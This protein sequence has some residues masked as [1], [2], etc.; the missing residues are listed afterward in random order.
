VITVL[1]LDSDLMAV[2]KAVGAPVERAAQEAAAALPHRFRRG[3]DYLEPIHR[4]DQPVS[5]VLLLGRNKEAVAAVADQFR[6]RT[7]R[8]SYLAVCQPPQGAMPELGRMTDL[9]VIDMQKNKTHL[10]TDP[11]RPGARIAEAAVRKVGETD[12][13]WVLEI[14]LIT[15]RHH[16]I[17]AQL[18]ARGVPIVGDLKY[19]ARRSKRGGG[20]YLH[21]HSIVF[22]HP[23]VPTTLH[24]TAPLPTGD[25]LWRAAKEAFTE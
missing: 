21:A 18:A 19:G 15:G 22:R 6:G 10:V 13:Y 25:R 24:I 1:Y 7:A 11:T 14:E 2:N 3:T 9:V 17:R 5:G 4:I 8:R 12:R 23:T 16:Q 20:I